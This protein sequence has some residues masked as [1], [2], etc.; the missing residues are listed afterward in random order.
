M[1]E[2]VILW[3]HRRSTEGERILDEF[4][5]RTGLEPDVRDDV[6]Y[7]ELRGDAHRTP[8][9]QTLTDIDARWTA[10][11]GLKLPA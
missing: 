11:V 1:S 6:R 3:A 8:I 9:V 7:Y 2:Q 5:R 4:Q 10:H